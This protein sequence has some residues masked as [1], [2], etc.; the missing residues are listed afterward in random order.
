[1]YTQAIKYKITMYSASAKT[2][3]L[4]TTFVSKHCVKSV[5]IWS[6]FWSAFPCN[7]DQKYGPEITPYLDTFQAAKSFGT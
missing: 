2:K 7:T 1:M 6:H 4:F 5:Q 3:N